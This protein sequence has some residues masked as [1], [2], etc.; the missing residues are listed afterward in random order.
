MAARFKGGSS[1]G[2]GALGLQGWTN[3]RTPFIGSANPAVR[4]GELRR[5]GPCSNKQ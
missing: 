5:G 1:R 4:I 3:G 2:Q